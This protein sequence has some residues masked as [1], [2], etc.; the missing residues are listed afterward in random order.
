MTSSVSHNTSQQTIDRPV[1]AN[2]QKIQAHLASWLPVHM[3][4]AKA[5]LDPPGK[6]I[7]DVSYL[8]HQI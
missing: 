4:E 3:A 2:T 1:A 8:T 5:V 6:Q 7:L